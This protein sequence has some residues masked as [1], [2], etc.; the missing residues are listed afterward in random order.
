MGGSSSPSR[1][2]EGGDSDISAIRPP[3]LRDCTSLPASV[4][5]PIVDLLPPLLLFVPPATSS[6]LLQQHTR[7]MRKSFICFRSKTPS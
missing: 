4:T 7:A 3:G 6:L 1:A 5:L 2:T